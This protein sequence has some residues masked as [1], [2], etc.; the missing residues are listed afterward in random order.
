MT[1]KINNS[2]SLPHDLSPK[3][4]FLSAI[5]YGVT[6]EVEK[7]LGISNRR[8]E[9]IYNIINELK[10]DKITTILSEGS[11]LGT[12]QAYKNFF[13]PFTNWFDVNSIAQ[14][15][16]NSELDKC[17]N[18]PISSE[19]EQT[20]IENI[21]TNHNLIRRLI[22]QAKDKSNLITPLSAWRMLR[23]RQKKS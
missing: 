15:Q 23:T 1:L 13:Q 21:R 2:Y 8:A 14:D 18:L 22:K 7:W 9:T 10:Q 20:F 4:R 5:R 11:K 6:S 12:L 16:Y 3:K 17:N 19:V